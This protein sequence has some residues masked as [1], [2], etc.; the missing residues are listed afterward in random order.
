MIDGFLSKLGLMK[1]SQH[2][3]TIDRFR[4]ALVHNRRGVRSGDINRLTNSWKTTTLSADAQAQNELKT[5]VARTRELTDSNNY[6]NKFVW[7]C[8]S[9]VL[10]DCG[11]HFRNKAKDPDKVVAGKLVTGPLDIFANKRIEDAW[12]KWSKKENCSVNQGLTFFDIQGVVLESAINDGNIFIRKVRGYSN[13]FRF[14]L[15]LIE[16]DHLDIEFNKRLD[17]GNKIRMGVETDQWGKRVAYHFLVDN[18]NDNWFGISPTLRRERVPASDVIHLFLPRRPNQTLG[19]PWMKTA[20]GHMHMAGAYEE[21]EVT[22]SRIGASSM[23]FIQTKGEVE[24]NGEKDAAGNFLMD[25]EPGK[26]EQLPEGLEFQPWN[27]SHPNSGYG[28]FMKTCLRG[29]A[30]GLGGVSYNTLA[31]DMESVNFASGK[32]GLDEERQYW[33]V[34]QRWFIEHFCDEVYKVWLQMAIMSG[35]VPLPMAKFEKFYAPEW[36]GRRWDYINPQQ[37]VAA[38]AQR[39]DRGLT[40]ISREL[41]KIGEDRDELFQE[42]ADDK[43]AAEALGLT[44]DDA[45]SKMELEHTKIESKQQ[46][47]EPATPAS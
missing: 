38:I 30:A 19:F 44:F 4:S 1:R 25:M 26:I 3:Q 8:K 16:F 46:E 10:G 7:M 9:N 33:K 35:E 39:L 22:A 47:P 42:I 17:G 28:D 43:A 6:A 2:E 20:A 24:Y 41:A 13:P 31:N 14:A 40:S 5:D 11:I 12:W 23:G 36:R 15:Q 34:I 29:I 45:S 18:P 27:P 32:L 37:E 21:A